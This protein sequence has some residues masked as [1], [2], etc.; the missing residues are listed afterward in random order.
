MLDVTDRKASEALV[1]ESEAKFR[2]FVD[3]TYDWEYW[4]NP[5]GRI[6]YTSPSCERI[7]GYPADD[8]INNPDMLD[9]I[10]YPEDQEKWAYH[11]REIT[12]ACGPKHIDFRIVDR[13]GQI[14]WIAHNCR[15]V[16]GPDGAWLGRRAS[17]RDITER[18]NTE[19]EL[20]EHLSMI[21]AILVNA[22]E[23]ICVCHSV[24]EYPFVSFTHW[25]ERMTETTGYSMDEIN[26]RGWYQSMYPDPELQNRAIERMSRMRVG[27]NLRGEEWVITTKGG[28]ARPVLISTTLMTDAKG[29][30]HV[31]AVM[32]DITDR[33]HMEEERLQIERK[34]LHT[35]KLESLAVMAG[36]IAHD[37][38]NQLAVVLGNLELA[39]TDQTLD[40]ETLLSIESA[41]ECGQA[42]S[43]SL[44]PDADL[45]GQHRVFP[46]RHSSKRAVEQGP[47][48]TEIDCF[49][50][51]CSEL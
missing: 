51:C 28:Q 14:V 5:D 8:F 42:I 48:P 38:N 24:D 17:N 27:Y 6:E 25:N 15:G 40:P 34:L 20:N 18:I 30:N 23:G 16:F 37:F 46:C 1:K 11:R 47:R 4:I 39:L 36:G 26:R 21:E 32:H 12:S 22:A 44:P 13:D 49:Q 43:G 50:V 41:V 9:S 45:H 29:T 35:Q 7:T 33:K 19:N 2:T 31:L 10:V 3:F